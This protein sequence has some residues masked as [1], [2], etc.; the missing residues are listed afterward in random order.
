MRSALYSITYSL[1]RFREFQI[2]MLYS[3]NK[4]NATVLFAFCFFVI[5]SLA[6]F[7][8]LLFFIFRACLESFLFLISCLF[9]ALASCCFLDLVIVFFNFCVWSP[10]NLSNCFIFIHSFVIVLE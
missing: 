3:N 10:Y 7:A 5:V 9:L 4:L 8:F 6:W 1:N 2:N